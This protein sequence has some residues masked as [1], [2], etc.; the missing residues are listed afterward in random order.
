MANGESILS[1]DSPLASLGMTTFT[2]PYGRSSISASVPEQYKPDLITLTPHPA[3]TDPLLAVKS[4]LDGLLGKVSWED[5]SGVKT[6]AVAINDKTRPVP[7]QYLL[8][9]LLKKLESLGLAAQ[10]IKLI[11]A[12]G[13]HQPMTRDEFAAVLPDEILARYPV[14]CH[15]SDDV[16]NLINLGATGRGTPVRINRD[17]L[18]ADL[19]IV[20]GNIEP[21]QFQ[22]FSG[23]AKSAAIGLA[24]RNTINHNHAMMTDKAARLGHYDHNPPRQDVEE[25]G[26]MIGIH[27]AL[28]AILND[29]KE[30]V[31]VVA[32]EPT[33]VMS[34]G[35][36]LAQ[37]IC[38]A[39]VP[40]Q[41]DLIIASPGGHPKDINVYQ[42]Q[43]GLAHASLITR[44]GGTVILV[45]ACPEGTGSLGY[46]RWV[47]AIDSNE[48]VLA[49][50]AQQEFQ[51]GPHKAFQIA[52]DATRVNVLLVSEMD[53][54]FVRQL[55][56]TPATSLQD[57]LDTAVDQ[58]PPKARVGIMPKANATIPQMSA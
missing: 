31:K 25:I 12:T 2:I 19:R 46:E 18:R 29:K 5:F 32:G 21:H 39:K 1:C 9:P 54:D 50:F 14:L 20:V 45:A 11:I 10:D 52:R 15:D 33:A 51:I 30:I 27:L 44:D 43:K 40:A 13:T 8:P 55:L 7:H 16:D 34:A 23:G 56:L 22:G 58:L 26:R 48:T 4:A 36:L 47:T 42:A 3:V 38:L 37:A 57:V 35:I 24:G 49:R 28:N 17:Y 41:Y 6:A 53:P